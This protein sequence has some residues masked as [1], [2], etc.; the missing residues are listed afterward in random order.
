AA[1]SPITGG[2]PTWRNAAPQSLADA[3]TSTSCSNSSSIGLTPTPARGRRRSGRTG[4]DPRRQQP[5][6]LRRLQDVDEAVDRQSS[7]MYIRR[8]NPG[9]VDVAR[10]QHVAPVDHDAVVDAFDAVDQIEQEIGRA[11]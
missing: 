3:S 10:M 7:G 8:R 1:I 4:P 9:A 6:S 11:H 5:G 2:W